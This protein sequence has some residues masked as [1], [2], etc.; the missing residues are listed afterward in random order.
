MLTYNIKRILK[1]RLITQPVG[2]L[3][4]HGFTKPTA[5]RLISGKT[6]NITTKQLEKLCLAFNCTPN[7]LMDWTP[8]NEK[9]LEQK[10]SLHLLIHSDI[11]IELKEFV[12][13]IPLN[14]LNDFTK[15]IEEIKK[16]YI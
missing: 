14:K 7:D 5:Q 6:K 15:E 11:P 9:Q 3:S 1:A 8:D 10:P 16:R 2:Y 12:E 13:N 4:R